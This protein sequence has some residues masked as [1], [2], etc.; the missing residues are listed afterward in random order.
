MKVQIQLA[1]I[2][3]IFL[4]SSPFISSKL[5]R[6]RDDS[7]QTQS[8]DGEFLYMD[9]LTGKKYVAG[10]V[11]P[12]LARYGINDLSLQEGVKIVHSISAV[13]MPKSTDKD[14]DSSNKEV[15]VESHNKK[16][17]TFLELN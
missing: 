17:S 13:D 15:Y 2:T 6:K 11:N 16:I 8:N 5:Q 10:F 14:S 12:N 3:C 4:I 1:L 9:N 7:N